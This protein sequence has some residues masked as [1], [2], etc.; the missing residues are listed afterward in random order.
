MTVE[1]GV[2]KG[3]FGSVMSSTPHNLQ[4]TCCL[5]RHPIRWTLSILVLV[6]FLA[7]FPI[8][9]QKVPDDPVLR[10]MNG[11]AQQQLQRRVQAIHKIHTIAEADR[12]KQAVHTNLI[13]DLGGL[14]SYS[15]PLNARTTGEIRNDTFTIEKVV[16]DSLPGFYVT[17]NLYRPNQPGRY[18]AVL[19][20]SGHTQEGKAEN[21]R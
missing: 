12:R 1:T 14:P 6:T 11:I 8:S 5:L 21:Q 17:A 10:W 13:H 18:P 9:A 16:Y 4:P 2:M 15:G 20:Q 19:L 3:Y 7:Q